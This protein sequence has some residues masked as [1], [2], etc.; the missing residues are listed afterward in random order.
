MVSIGKLA[1][2][3]AEYYLNQARGRVSVAAA[4]ASGVEDYYLDGSEPDGAWLGNGAAALGLRGKVEAGALN[5]VLAGR[6]PADGAALRLRGSVPG[7]DV[8][9]SAP[10]SVSVIFGVAAPEVR[11]AV[12]AAHERAVRQAFGYLENVAAVARRGASGVDSVAGNGLVAAGFLHRTSRAGDPQL[13]THVLVANMTCGPDGRWTAL[14]ARLLYAQ[15]RTAGFLYQAAL[16]AELSRELGVRWGPIRNGV[17]EIDGVPT[18][19]LRAFS[20]RRAEIDQALAERGVCGPEA[21][22]VATLATRRSKDYRVTPTALM[23]EWR[24]RAAK[25]GLSQGRLQ[26]LLG[27]AAQ[28]PLSSDE[29]GAPVQRPGG[30]ARSHGAALELHPRG[31]D[32][33]AVRAPYRGGAD[34]S[35]RAGSGYVPGGRSRR[36]APRHRS[37]ITAGRGDPAARRAACDR[38]E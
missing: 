6:R 22:R 13:H 16:G 4:V 32:P 17:A 20:R 37:V 28:R 18:R 23:P 7:F 38:R 30:G 2:G 33:R 5:H 31:C 14:D 21:A 15:G 10:K 24:H 8:T 27:R 1:A 35:R 34:R 36:P 29:V 12:V 19:V 9:F 11:A 3:Q 25:V 26:A